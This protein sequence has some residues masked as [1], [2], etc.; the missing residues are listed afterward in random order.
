M[1]EHKSNAAHDVI[2]PAEFKEQLAKEGLTLKAWATE[3]GY[4]PEYCSRVL[5]GM[6]KGTRGK[7][8]EIA[9]AMRIK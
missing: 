2:T 3:R 5:T 7:G 9:K 1:T 4:D 8:H 6:V